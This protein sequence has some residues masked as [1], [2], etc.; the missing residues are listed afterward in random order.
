M[1]TVAKQQEHLKMSGVYFSIMNGNRGND[2]IVTFTL[3][4]IKGCACIL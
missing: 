1:F 3:N 4:H 2:L